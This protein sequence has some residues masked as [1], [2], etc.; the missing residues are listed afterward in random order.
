[1]RGVLLPPFFLP[2]PEDLA[3]LGVPLPS[4]TTAVERR[5]VRPRPAP[6]PS[7]TTTTAA[8]RRAVR[9]VHRKKENGGRGSTP[10][11]RADR[12]AARRSPTAVL[13]AAPEAPRALGAPLP[14]STTTTAAERRA[15]RVVHRKKEN[16]G[17]GSTP[18]ARAGRQTCC[19]PFSYRRSSFR[20]RRTS[21]AGGSLALLNSTAVERRAVRPRPAPAA[22]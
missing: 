5:D 22:F 13:P 21:R 18:E 20:T 11:A 7:S 17:R 1:P 9:I 6:L 4:S 10:E 19:P 14:S 2:H 8:E 12:P 3:T 15:V 16:G